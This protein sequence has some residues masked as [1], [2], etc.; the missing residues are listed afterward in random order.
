MII[1]ES[2]R[3]AVVG[4][5]FPDWEFSTLF[6]LERLEVAEI[7]RAWPEVDESEERVDLAVRNALNNLTGYPHGHERDWDRFLSVSPARL[8]E[9]L[10]RWRLPRDAH[11]GDERGSVC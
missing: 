2:L 6:G 8:T 5:F 3:A 4:P 10:R 9:T 1:A 7:A 11:R